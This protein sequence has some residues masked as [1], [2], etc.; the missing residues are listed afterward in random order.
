MNREQ[1][2]PVLLWAG[3]GPHYRLNHQCLSATDLKGDQVSPDLA[4]QLLGIARLVKEVERFIEPSSD[5]D[6]ASGVPAGEQA[7]RR[8]VMVRH[9]RRCGRSILA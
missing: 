5:V 8:G 2:R 1:A 6:G 3:E 9:R 7:K 4:E